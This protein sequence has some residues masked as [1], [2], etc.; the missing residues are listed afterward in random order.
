[1]SIRTRT[2]TALLLTLG[3][4]QA[5]ALE[6]YVTGAQSDRQYLAAAEKGESAVR[7][8]R[9]G[10][11]WAH[12]K[13]PSFE[14]YVAGD[15]FPLARQATTL[16]HLAQLSQLASSHASFGPE[17]APRELLQAMEDTLSGF[18]PHLAGQT[19]NPRFRAR[20]DLVAQLTLVGPGGKKVEVQLDEI[21]RPDAGDGGFEFDPSLATAPEAQ[22]RDPNDLVLPARSLTPNPGRSTSWHLRMRGRVLSDLDRAKVTVQLFEAIQQ[23][24]VEADRQREAA[25]SSLRA[26]LLGR[27]F[28]LRDANLAG[29]AYDQ[30]PQALQAR[31]Q[32]HLLQFPGRFGWSDQ[33]EVDMFLSRSRVG[34]MKTAPMLVVRYASDGRVRSSGASL[35]AMR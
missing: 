18:Y 34:E 25:A 29:A 9:A 6:L 33:S 20:L 21:I 28:G 32:Q 26:T 1:M 10:P 2:L 19:G 5:S 3:W 31:L 24:L 15:A 22:P 16:R 27:A 7:E 4:T 14:A 17:N 8:L 23:R 12:L 13:L 30:L 11:D 35:D